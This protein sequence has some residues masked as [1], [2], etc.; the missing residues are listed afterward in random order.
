MRDK[1]IELV[2]KAIVDS[3][4]LTDVVDELLILY[5][6]KINEERNSV[7]QQCQT[8]IGNNIKGG[9]NHKSLIGKLQKAERH[10]NIVSTTLN[11][12]RDL[13]KEIKSLKIDFSIMSEKDGTSDS[14][15][16]LHDVIKAKRTVCDHDW[17]PDPHPATF[18]FDICAKCG[19]VR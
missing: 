10:G 17:Q 9:K 8:I 6:T 11:F 13:Q 2:I 3:N 15:L 4:E 12:S 18:E 14:G 16:V 5:N 7:V 19:D 1:I